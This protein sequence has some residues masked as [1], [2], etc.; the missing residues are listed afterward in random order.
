MTRLHTM[1]L[2]I[3]HFRKEKIKK[4]QK[5]FGYQGFGVGGRGEGLGRE[6]ETFRR[7]K[8]FYR[9]QK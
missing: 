9:I 8:V 1:I 4:Y 5:I 7:V 6:Q 2:S 3:W